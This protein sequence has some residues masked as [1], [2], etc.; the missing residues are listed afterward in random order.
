MILANYIKIFLLLL[1]IIQSSSVIKSIRTYGNGS[2]HALASHVLNNFV[3]PR[4]YN[5]MLRGANAKR[6][7][8]LQKFLPNSLT[9]QSSNYGS[10]KGS[11]CSF[12]QLTGFNK[13]IELIEI[14]K[15][16]KD[17]GKENGGKENDG[18]ENIEKENNEKSD[19]K[20]DGKENVEKILH[21][22][23]PLVYTNEDAVVFSHNKGSEVST[24]PIEF[25]EKTNTNITGCGKKPM[26]TT[27][28][29]TMNK[30][31]MI[32]KKELRDRKSF[33]NRQK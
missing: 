10:I 26:N 16:E 33:F 19:E 27:H 23:N 24:V 21:T 30:N 15:N 7:V 31:S 5:D 6:T 12:D 14:K 17:D 25:A 11:N 13:N 9:S 28:A 32:A 4:D 1:N 8:N 20:D 22:Q 18:K 3:K 29:F 2:R